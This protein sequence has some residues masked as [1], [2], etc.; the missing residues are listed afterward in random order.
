MSF[1]SAGGPCSLGH[2]ILSE[3]VR[4]EPETI[5]QVHSWPV[6]TSVEDVRSFLRLA[7][8]YRRFTA[9]FATIAE[10]L[11]TILQKTATFKWPDIEQR[12]FNYLR[13]RLCITSILVH[14]EFPN[15][16][17]TFVRNADVS[18]K[19]EK[20]R[21]REVNLTNTTFRDAFG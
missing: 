13:D 15:V 11:T 12:P 9:N 5:K 20:E 8:Y 21:W 6:S 18:D 16:T 1:S 7:S 19:S 4:C 10:P 2:I 17:G 3:G 14:T